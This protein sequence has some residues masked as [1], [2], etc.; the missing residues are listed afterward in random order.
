[1]FTE[2]EYIWFLI[3]VAADNATRLRKAA[4]Q[5]RR[6]WVEVHGWPLTKLAWNW[7]FKIFELRPQLQFA[8]DTRTALSHL[9]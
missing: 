2:D 5:D 6:C 7:S 1:M 8:S 4:N 9:V 3:L